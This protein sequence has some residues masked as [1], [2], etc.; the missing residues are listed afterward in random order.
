MNPDP[1]V[2]RRILPAIT[3]AQL[4]GTSLW[5][6]GNAIAPDLQHDW[7]LTG[8]PAAAL[9]TA[10]Q[11]GFIAGTLVYALLLIADRNSPR[12][13]YLASSLLAALANAAVLV[14]PPA[15]E[16]MVVTRFLVGFLLA[17]IYPVGMRIAASWYRTGLG[18]ALGVLIG[19]LFV[20]TALPHALRALGAEWPWQ[21]VIAVLSLLAAA[22][23]V[24]L[25]LTVPDGPWL[26]RGGA[27]R[28]GALAVIVRD[29]TVRASVF[30]YFG[31]MWELY[32]M[33]MVVPA[34]FTLRLG[35]DAATAISWWAFAA[36][37]AGGFGAAAGGMLSRRFGSARVAGAQLAIS[38][39]CCL[40]APWLIDAPVWLFAG[41]M[42]VWGTT[43]A[44]DSPQFS[45]LTARNCPPAI[46]GSVLT[47]VNCIG[48]AISIVT[49]QAVA[50]AAARQPL[51]TVLPWLAIG[52]AAGLL[53]MMPL[54]RNARNTNRSSGETGR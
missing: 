23:G 35:G 51:P 45:A 49:I 40:L 9:T 21:S 50:A 52:P 36:I 33:L 13:V 44:G 46:V 14:L 12:L 3:L 39:G 31:H 6:A 42:L 34:L 8:D 20:G 22:G 37:A 18:L 19:A 2:P 26:V 29:R 47:L 38:G 53:F 17:G 28:V 48:F 15:L 32:A 43:V 24:L 30:G 54:L 5:F 16:A 1:P 27:I 4:C 10:V 7:R 41:W 11:A 25:A